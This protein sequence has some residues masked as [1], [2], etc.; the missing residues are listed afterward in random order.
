ML[1]LLLLSGIMGAICAAGLPTLI[2]ALVAIFMV[3]VFFLVAVF[4]GFGWFPAMGWTFLVS[5]FLSAGF[6]ATHLMFY[7]MYVRRPTRRHRDAE[8]SLE[9]R[10]AREINNP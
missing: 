1:W 5:T 2:F 8:I 3:T 7:A 9:P 4:S 6:M 10:P